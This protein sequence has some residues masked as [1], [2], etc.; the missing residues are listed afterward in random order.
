MMSRGEC[1]C[2][3][4]WMAMP[5]SSM[6]LSGRDRYFHASE[7]VLKISASARHTG[8]VALAGRGPSAGGEGRGEGKEVLRGRVLRPAI[9]HIE[10]E[11]LLATR[12][13]AETDRC[14]RA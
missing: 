4:F 5:R 12:T 6:A 1:Q 11:S 9:S 3:A 2:R 7:R 8:A 10:F 14:R 13:G